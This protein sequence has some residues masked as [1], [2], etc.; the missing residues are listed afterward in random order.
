MEISVLVLNYNWT[1]TWTDRTII[2]STEMKFLTS[3]AEF[4]V[5]DF[6]INIGL[7]KYI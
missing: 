7:L 6:K 5:L 1:M 4:T 3:V 2:E